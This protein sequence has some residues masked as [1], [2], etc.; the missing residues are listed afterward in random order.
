MCVTRGTRQFGDL[1]PLDPKGNKILNGANQFNQRRS[2][3]TDIQTFVCL[4]VKS[5]SGKGE[6]AIFQTNFLETSKLSRQEVP[7]GKLVHLIEKILHGSY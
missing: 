5:V 3:T 7:K 4:M 1:D 2:E 6:N